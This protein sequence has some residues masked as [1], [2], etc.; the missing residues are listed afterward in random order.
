M[1]IM[2]DGADGAGKST[3]L[4]FWADFL[5]QQG[6]RVFSLK[7]FWQKHRR[8]PEKKEW[9][10][11]DVIVSAEPT[12]VGVGQVIREELIKKQAPGYP[13]QAMA[14]A[15]SLDRL[16]LYQKVLLPALRA[17]KIIIQDRGVS[18]SLVYQPLQH[19]TLTIK[20]VAVL[21]GN[22]LALQWAPDYLVVV[23]IKPEIALKRLAKRF[24]KKDNTIF[25]NPVSLKRNI[26]TY[27]ALVFQRLFHKYGAKIIYLE[28][29]FKIDIMKEEAVRLLKKLLK[30]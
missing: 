3:I 29:N 13:P 24:Q 16:I 4:G 11:F 8:H 23:E 26:D 15:F 2:I 27:H 6:R 18:T 28:N 7:N 22:E 17:G 20:K 14:E 30:I 25:E 10:D 5:K 9:R 21:P 12:Y 1:F 19:P